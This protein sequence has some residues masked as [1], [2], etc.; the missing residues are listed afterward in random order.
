MQSTT[1]GKYPH[2]FKT[3]GSNEM[4]YAGVCVNTE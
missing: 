3:N 4:Y 1:G 2:I